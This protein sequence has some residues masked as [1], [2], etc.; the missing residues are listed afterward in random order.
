MAGHKLLDGEVVDASGFSEAEHRFLKELAEDG[1][2]GAEYFD[3]LRRVKGPGA[4]PLRGGRLTPRIARS[5][6]YRV[7]HD[8]ADRVGIE[9]GYLLAP[10]VERPV[11]RRVESDLLSL[12]EAAE[13][14]G[15]SRPAAHQALVEGRLKGQRVGNA[16]VVRR[17][18]ATAFKETREGRAAGSPVEA[19][20]GG[21][22]QRR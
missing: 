14:I 11:G 16:W 1:R 9:Q 2:R 22:G 20:S 18:D 12:T 4:L 3:L 21:R 5:P 8:V 13:L 7:A 19:T 6:F 10:D 17:A 15:I